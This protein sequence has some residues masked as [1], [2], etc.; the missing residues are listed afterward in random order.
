[1]APDTTTASKKRRG[2]DT[3]LEKA[4]AA[5]EQKKKAKPVTIVV[6]SGGFDKIMSAFIIGNGYL[7]I[8]YP[9]TLYFTFWGLRALTHGGFDRAPLS[10]MNF[11]GLG[12]YMIK[13]KMKKYNV[14]SLEELVQSYRDLG[15]KVI[16]CTMTMEAMGVDRG[17]IRDEL[18]D[19]YG[20]V[21]SYV[22]ASRDA[23]ATLFI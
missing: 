10:K 13:R 5:Q 1:M 17:D 12:R 23:S 22:Y 8:G 6:H 4:P 20:T 2:K 19:Q 14:R 9:V 3:G 15:G 11:F 21:G 16:A 7:S 18:V